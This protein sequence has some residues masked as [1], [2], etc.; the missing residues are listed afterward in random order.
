MRTMS[1]EGARLLTDEEKRR[2]LEKMA[3]LAD[4]LA[5]RLETVGAAMAIMVGHKALDQERL[6]AEKIGRMLRW[7]LL[8]KLK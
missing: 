7:V 8:E 4:S 1:D 5:L 3:E 2:M 6:D